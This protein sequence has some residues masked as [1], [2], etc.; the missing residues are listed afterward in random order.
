[1]PQ[2]LIMNAGTAQM[3]G[4]DLTA[5]QLSLAAKSAW[6][7]VWLAQEGDLIV[8]PIPIPADLLSFVGSTL[9]FD[10]ASLLLF[11]PEGAHDHP[12]LCDVTLQSDAVVERISHI[13]R[14]NTHWKISACYATEGV[15]RL[16]AVLGIAK[17]GDKFALQR[18]P[19]LL[20]RKS[21]FRQLATSVAL[22]LANGCV[23]TSSDELLA[24]VT[25]LRSETGNVILK[26]DN[27]AGGAGN[28][29]LTSKKTT[30]LP[31]ARETRRVHWPTFDPDAV[32]SEMTT[33]SCRT[34]V[35]ESYHLARSMFY[36][37]FEIEEK[38]AIT[39]VNSGDIRLRRS[40][41]RSERALVWTG[42][43]LPSDMSNRQRSIAHAH[44]YRFAELARTL[45]YRGLINIDAIFS[46][47]GRLL[48]NEANGRW[49]GGSV[50]HSIAARLLGSDYSDSC[51]VSSVRD[52]RSSSLRAAIDHFAKRGW[53]FDDTRKEGLIPLAADQ[54]AGTVECLVIAHDRLSARN[55][56]YRLPR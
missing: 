42:L 25:C 8:S 3:S 44:A 24:A 39:Y 5:I 13:V 7:S 41:D 31:G 10:P 6:R 15:A 47:D 43:E 23:A 11:V 2:I 14:Q 1:M 48:F 40:K 32:W 29:V 54:D 22:P 20:N 19:D 4:T 28:I 18:G 33:P 50:L 37:E 38:G 12:V 34:L 35:V 16:A 36:L 27:G 51:V 53:L 56:Q 49:G 55:L 52:V 21:H 17:D 45:G 46:T 26:L 30:P 9:K